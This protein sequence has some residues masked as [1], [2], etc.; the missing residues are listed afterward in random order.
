VKKNSENWSA[1]AEVRDESMRLPFYETQCKNISKTFLT[2]YNLLSNRFDNQLN[3]C[4]HDTSSWLYH[5]YK[6]STGC[7]THLT[8]GC[9]LYTTGCQIS[10]NWS[11]W[12]P[13]ER[14][15]AVRSN[16]CQTGW[17][18]SGCSFNTA[19]KPV[20]QLVVSCKRG[21]RVLVLRSTINNTLTINWP[22]KNHPSSYQKY[23]HHTMGKF[24]VTDDL[25][26]HIYIHKTLHIQRFFTPPSENDPVTF[27][28]N[29]FC[30]WMAY[31]QIFVQIGTEKN[32]CVL[33][34]YQ[35]RNIKMY[36]SRREKLKYYLLLSYILQQEPP[37]L[38]T[39]QLSCLHQPINWKR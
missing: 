39:Y 23:I 24:L 27:F 37:P 8:T 11:L 17:T 31:S 29:Y 38:A 35:V 32:E 9:I 12:Q 2:R 28:K 25:E 1:W 26:F 16:G 3:D 13:V 21:I 33:S 34:L 7:Q 14:T 19:V 5:V 6:H 30:S 18:N 10:E 4:I 22:N 15:V 36:K 20:V